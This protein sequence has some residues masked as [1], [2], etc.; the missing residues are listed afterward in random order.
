MVLRKGAGA[1]IN[2]GIER[3]QAAILSTLPGI[4]TDALGRPLLSAR[5]LWC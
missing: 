4:A 3:G 2:S 5:S 1:E